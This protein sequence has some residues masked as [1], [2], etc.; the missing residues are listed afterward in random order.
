MN[1]KKRFLILLLTVLFFASSSLTSFAQTGASYLD[2]QEGESSAEADYLPIV[3]DIQVRGNKII[4]ANTILNKIKTR[5]GAPLSREE[6]NE[7]IK[8]LYRTQY[9]QDVK[10]DLA[11]DGNNYKVVVVVDEKPVVKEIVIEGNTQFPEDAVRKDLGV[12]EGQVLAQHILKQGVNNIKERYRNKGYKFVS[13]NTNID[14]NDIAKEATIYVTIGEGMK[15]KIG[16]IQ[17][18]GVSAFKTSQLKRKMQTKENWYNIPFVPGV[19]KEDKFSSDIERLKFFYQKEGYLDVAIASDFEYDEDAKRMTIIL[20]VDEGKQY[21]AGK[22]VFQGN[23]LFP[24]SEIWGKLEMLPGE[25][26]SQFGLHAD[27]DSIKRFYF[28]RG[29]INARISS[30]T[31]L[32]K[33][34]GRVDIRYTISEGELYYIDKVKIRGNT[35]TKDLVIRRELRV[36]PGERFDGEKLEYSKQRLNNLGYFEEVIYETEPGTAPDKRDVVFAVKE[37]QT[38]ELSFGAG[39]SSIDQ[40]IG[41]AEISQRNFDLFKWPTFTGGGQSLSL[42]GRMGSVTQDLDL[43]FYEPYILNKPVSFGLNVFNWERDGNNLDFDTR[44]RGI[45]VTFGKNFTDRVKGYVGYTIEDVKISNIESDADP[46]VTASGI[47]N[48]LSRA[49]AG[50]TYD[51]RDNVF[52][53]KSGWLI[54]GS[55]ELI[56]SMLAGDQ[57]YYIFQGGVTKYF[58]FLDEHVIELKGRGGVMNDFG[59]SNQVPVFDRFFAGGLGSVRGYNYRRVGPKGGGDAIGG[60]TLVTGTVEYTFPIIENF[61]GAAFVD[62]GHVNSD[63]FEVDTGDFAVSIGPGLKINTPLGPVTLYYGF[64]I[65]NKDDEDENGRFEFNLSRGF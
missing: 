56:G 50:L 23:K 57:D 14:V 32:N 52:A 39:I 13:V 27:V 1:T 49:K 25:V 15:Y 21:R 41:F 30:E 46:Q 20:N 6:I 62:A 22:V 26:Y 58:S 63:F 51:S 29:Y 64:P 65:V 17:F 7:D 3:S 55:A 43:S 8:R 33:E 31:S 2:G 53:P 19:F 48:L 38:G 45:G 54:N 24:E 12:S 4:S 37:K 42:R 47:E 61:K 44:R 16:D 59:D 36:R 60:E 10:F 34:T 35:K 9:F 11:P 5:A 28:E 40:F 18:N